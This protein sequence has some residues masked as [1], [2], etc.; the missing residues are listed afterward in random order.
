M[1]QIFVK[2]IDLM[3]RI[4]ISYES[5]GSYLIDFV[6]RAGLQL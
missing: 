3:L 5:N 4:R 2:L 1:G 6:A